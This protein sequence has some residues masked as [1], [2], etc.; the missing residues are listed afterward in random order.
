VRMAGFTL[1]GV[2]L[3]AVVGGCLSEPHNRY[4]ARVIWLVPLI[5]LVVALQWRRLQRPG[6][7]A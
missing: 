3:N 5:A 7:V 4:Q 2:A 1:L 6:A